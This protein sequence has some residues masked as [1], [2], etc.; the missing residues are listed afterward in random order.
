MLGLE[1]GK[2]MIN[3]KATAEEEHTGL[4]SC[5]NHGRGKSGWKS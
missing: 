1:K 5:L 3:S 4:G 2:E